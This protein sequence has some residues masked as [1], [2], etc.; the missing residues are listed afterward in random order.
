MRVN[1]F[2]I[3]DHSDALLRRKFFNLK[4][5]AWFVD[6]IFTCVQFNCHACL[7]CISLASTTLT[8]RVWLPFG[9]DF[10]S[11]TMFINSSANI[12]LFCMKRCYKKL[13]LRIFMGFDWLALVWT[14]QDL[15]EPNINVFV[16]N[17]LQFLDRSDPHRWWDCHNMTIS[18][19]WPR[20]KE[21][22]S[23]WD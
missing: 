20:M 9:I 19:E 3:Q 1:N 6:F 16:L 8:A 11:L 14:R 18:Y 12:C 22:I 17:R 10:H 4:V 15:V 7:R 13:R 2:Y 23:L 21:R 5:D